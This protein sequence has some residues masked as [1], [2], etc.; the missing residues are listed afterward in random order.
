[1]SRDRQ[2]AVFLDRDGV[3]TL[4]KSYVRSVE[5]LE[6]F[7]YS[8]EC[9]D[10]IHKKGYLAIIVT[11]QSGVARGYF[12]EESLDEMNRYLID[13]L[14]VD[15]I[16]YCPHYPGGIIPRYSIQC[17][18]RKPKTEMIK[19]ACLDY[20]I[21]QTTSWMVGDRESDI[22]L[23]INAGIRTVLLESGYGS[24]SLNAGITPDYILND[25]REFV[26]ML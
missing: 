16:Y 7:Y 6:V 10:R 1:M 17:N 2:P 8:R 18:C 12:S 23:G 20:N 13:L 11:N 14:G 21:D 24:E 5:E 9:I 22:Q 26:N 3:V 4:E 19:Q 15:A 25:L